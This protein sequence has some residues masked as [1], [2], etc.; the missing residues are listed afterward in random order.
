VSNSNVDNPVAGQTLVGLEAR[1]F[2]GRNDSLPI[3]QNLSSDFAATGTYQVRGND[4]CLQPPAAPTG[5][6][7]V[8]PR[9]G[10]IDL[11][12]VD[13]SGDE[14]S[15]LVERSTS[16][17]DGFAQIATVGPNVVTYA[18]RMVMRKVTYYYRVRA[19]RGVAKSGYSNIA[20]AKTK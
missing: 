4:S 12:W 19:A 2:L 6:V 9:K 11:T 8:S 15:F 3:N 1:S 10:E 14:D 20:S 5:L 13:G 16:P 7:A 18:D 17:T